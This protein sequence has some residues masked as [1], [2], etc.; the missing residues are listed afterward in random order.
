MDATLLKSLLTPVN[1]GVWVL[2]APDDPELEDVIDANATTAVLE[3]L[4]SH[5]AFTILDCEHHL[6]ERTLAAMDAADKVL[7]ITQLTVPALRSAQRTLGVG[8]RL[9]YAEDKFLVVVNRQ[10]A[11]DVLDSSDATNAIKHPVY[12]QLPND[13]RT[14]TDAQTRGIS[15][16]GAGPGSKLSESYLKLA[17]KLGGVT[18]APEPENGARR[19]SR[20]RGLF[21]AVKRS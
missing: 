4:R 13:Y 21:G 1:D 3:H 19:G 9:G 7:L 11:A 17:A 18:R 2:P 15:V 16:L 6:T 5:F 12:W 8:R 20:L 10:Q 14:S